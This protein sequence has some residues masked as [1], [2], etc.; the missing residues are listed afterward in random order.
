MKAARKQRPQLELGQP[1]LSPPI[2]EQ[3][4]YATK[5]L[6]NGNASA[7]QQQAFMRWLMF[8]LCVIGKSP[9]HPG[10]PGVDGARVTDF[11]LGM[12]QV[13]RVLASAMDAQV[14]PQPDPRGPPPDPPPVTATT[15]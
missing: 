4:I 5:A 9:F 3:I 1:W 8:E 11:T 2:P 6:N 7:G 10:A 13:A 14:K 15:S 12:Q